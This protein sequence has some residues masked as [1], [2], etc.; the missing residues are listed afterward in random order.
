MALAKQQVTNDKKKTETK[1]NVT[2]GGREVSVP[3]KTENVKATVQANTKQSV[4]GREINT[5]INKPT[6]PKTAGKQ[7]ENALKTNSSAQLFFVVLL[8]RV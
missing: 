4:G 5:G 3:A 1:Q 6:T 7:P 8:Q 2:V